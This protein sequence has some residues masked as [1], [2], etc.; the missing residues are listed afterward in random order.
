MRVLES[1]R[2]A[3]GRPELT[4]FGKNEEAALRAA[5]KAF[6]EVIA[7][8]VQDATDHLLSTRANARDLNMALADA[9]AGKL[10]TF[11]PRGTT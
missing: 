1:K 10:V 4:T 8:R 9:K 3:S 5:R 7:S 6:D 11:D 2:P